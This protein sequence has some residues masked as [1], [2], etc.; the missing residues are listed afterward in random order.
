MTW[1]K[2]LAKCCWRKREQEWGK[3]RE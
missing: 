2:Q 3:K 1:D